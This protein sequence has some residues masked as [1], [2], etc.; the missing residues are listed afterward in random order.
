M[1]LQSN[2]FNACM[3][4]ICQLFQLQIG[5]Y[6]R[7]QAYPIKYGCLPAQAFHM[8]CGF[9]CSAKCHMCNS[10]DWHNL[11]ENASW[12]GTCGDQRQ[13][14]PFKHGH[15]NP[16]LRIPGV[17]KDSIL[18]D[19]LHC[20]HLGW[21]Q[22]LAASAVVLL[23]KL[24]HFH[25]RCLNSKLATAYAEFMAWVGCNKKTTGID[26]WSKLKLD[27]VSILSLKLS[28]LWY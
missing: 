5:P 28:F 10:T 17:N 14:S 21:G 7:M 3:H 19:S 2:V 26:W 20:F 1:D 16:F 23:C 24:G 12:R 6:K 15:Q 13:G 22:D 18:P 4:I 9:Y 8:N 25:G 27:M 11:G